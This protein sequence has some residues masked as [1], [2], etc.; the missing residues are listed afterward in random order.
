[1][2]PGNEIVINIPEPQRWFVLCSLE[3]L[4]RNAPCRCCQRWVIQFPIAMPYFCWKNL[5]ST[6]KYV[7]P[8]QISSSSMMAA[9]FET[10]GS[11][12]MPSLWSLFLPT[13]RAS[14]TG[15]SVRRLTTSKL[16]RVSGD[17]RFTDFKNC[18]KWPEF[19]TEGSDFP[20]SWLDVLWRKPTR[21]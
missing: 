7:V 14:T 11:A 1:M 18:K 6:W 12:D 21:A 10:D 17:W 5:S 2:R 19:F 16:T 8:K 9:I 20:A 15:T 4:S 3:P 13:F